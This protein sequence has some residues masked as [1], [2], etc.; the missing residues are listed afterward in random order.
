[1]DNYTRKTGKGLENGTSSLLGEI[2]IIRQSL[3]SIEH[4]VGSPLVS[5]AD[6]LAT[7]LGLSFKGEVS[8]KAI[9]DNLAFKAAAVAM[10]TLGTKASLATKA[11]IYHLGET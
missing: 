2:G 6:W 4:Q 3:E 1:M 5:L 9:R 10:E 11:T 8:R 7:R